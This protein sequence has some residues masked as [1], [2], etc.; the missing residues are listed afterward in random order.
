[1]ALSYASIAAS[2]LLASSTLL[3]C[4]ASVAEPDEAAET[5]DEAGLAFGE[6]TCATTTPDYTNNTIWPP[7]YV[8]PMYAAT[9]GG[10]G[11]S[12]CTHAI[13]VDYANG[14]SY[15]SAIVAEPYTVPTTSGACGI[16]HVRAKTYEQV[17]G[18]WV[19]FEETRLHGVWSGGVC[20]YQFDSGYGSLQLSTNPTRAIAQAYTT[21]CLLGA[22]TTSYVGVKLRALTNDTQ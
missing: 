5:V 12:D 3:G 21:V 4:A 6:A 9:T 8:G 19:P 7:S 18:A 20:T 11:H 10:Y 1:M 16:S 13:V 15:S 17:G 22:C 14:T 2:I